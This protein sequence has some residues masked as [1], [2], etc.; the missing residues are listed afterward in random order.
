MSQSERIL[1]YL[2]QGKTLTVGQALNNLD[3]Y[4]L[5]QRVGELRRAGH[6]I[7]DEWVDNGRSRFK[8]YYYDIP[9]E[10]P[11]TDRLSTN[12]GVQG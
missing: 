2:K 9:P 11:F 10:L 3:C 5:S 6:P 1:N 7:K 4:A 12:L 8:R